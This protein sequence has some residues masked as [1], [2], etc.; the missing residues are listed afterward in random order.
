MAKT[1][2]A[3]IARAAPRTE[4][5]RKQLARRRRWH[6]RGAPAPP[7]LLSRTERR[8]A[9]LNGKKAQR[10]AHRPPAELNSGIMSFID[11]HNGKPNPCRWAWDR[12]GG[13]NQYTRSF[14]S[15]RDR[16]MPPSSAGVSGSVWTGR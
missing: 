3:A 12:G 4:K 11:A 6:V 1:V 16:S 8:F 9:E 15:I 5:V 14:G 7:S 10:G 13:E 2:L